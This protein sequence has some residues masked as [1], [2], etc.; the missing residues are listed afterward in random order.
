MIH[1]QETKT[2]I[3]L[4]L[5]AG[6]HAGIGLATGVADG[7]VTF[8]HNSV[9]FHLIRN[10]NKWP[11]N[12]PNIYIEAAC[13][14]KLSQGRIEDLEQ[15]L[16]VAELNGPN[17]SPFEHHNDGRFTITSWM[18]TANSSLNRQLFLDVRRML[19]NTIAD[20]FT[21]L[22]WVLNL[23]TDFPVTTPTG[24]L[25]CK[26][27]GH[28]WRA[29]ATADETVGSLSTSYFEIPRDAKFDPLDDRNETETPI[30]F[31][32]YFQA[33]SLAKSNQ[34]LCIPMMITAIESAIRRFIS[35]TVPGSE[36]IVEE[37]ASPPIVKMLREFIAPAI[38]KSHQTSILESTVQG[39]D[40]ELLGKLVQM[41]NRIMHGREVRISQDNVEKGLLVTHSLIWTLEHF[42]GSEWAESYAFE[43][44][45]HYRTQDEVAKS[46]L[47][48]IREM[49]ATDT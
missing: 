26:L 14:R 49:Q 10:P 1:N 18:R 24:L 28:S 3:G 43:N 11:R 13:S 25:E 44:P 46:Y 29:V 36:W 42:G 15:A 48:R 38:E 21:H 12:N 47:S 30:P 17:P 19:E 41:R 22:T 8:T 39:D 34:I 32:F 23:H 7:E 6:W 35:R 27:E 45:R 4:R 37:L 16:R 2:T 9:D 20:V 5:R 31:K 40:L 33:L